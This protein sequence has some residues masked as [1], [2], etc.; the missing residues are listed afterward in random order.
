MITSIRNRYQQANRK[1]YTHSIRMMSNFVKKDFS[2]S[3]SMCTE[4]KKRMSALPIN[5]DNFISS[6]FSS[7]EPDETQTFIKTLHHKHQSGTIIRMEKD[8]NGAV[9]HKAGKNMETLADLSTACVDNDIY[10]SV[11]EFYGYRRLHSRC[12][13]I[14]GFFIDLDGHNFDDCHRAEAIRL[15]QDRLL[16]AYEHKELLIPTMITSTGRGLGLFY[17]FDRT[18]PGQCESLAGL[19]DYEKWLYDLLAKEYAKILDGPQYLEVDTSTK[20]FSR[21]CRLPGTRNSHTGTTCRLY[22]IRRRNGQPYYYTLDEINKGCHLFEN[23]GIKKEKK[24]KKENKTEKKRKKKNSV[25]VISLSEYKNNGLQ[26]HRIEWLTKVSEIKKKQGYQTGYRNELLFQLYNAAVVIMPFLEAE[27]LIRDINDTFDVPVGEKEL[28]SVMT[29]VKVHGH[30]HQKTAT[31]IEKLRIGKETEKLGCRCSKE[32]LARMENKRIKKDRNQ[33]IVE[34]RTQ[35]PDYTR[36]ELLKV[37][38]QR[39]YKCSLR[40]M[41]RVLKKAGMS[42]YK[43]TARSESAPSTCKNEIA[44][45][46]SIPC[47]V[48]TAET[49]ALS[50]LA[51]LK[52][53]NSL[54][55]TYEGSMVD[56]FIRITS[57]IKEESLKNQVMQ[58]VAY[59]GCQYKNREEIGVRDYYIND[60]NFIFQSMNQGNVKL[61]VF[62]SRVPKKKYQNADITYPDTYTYEYKEKTVNRKVCSIKTMKDKKTYHRPV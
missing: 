31:I 10:I 33:A 54:D 40:T 20:D 21:V 11:N 17:V 9:S 46:V 39:G 1:G 5:H 19:V 58:A 15:T 30:Y 50:F 29:S 26:T 36:T 45:T 28:Q 44:K 25:S 12:S 6:L 35:H 32:L 55:G 41:D 51:F 23:N 53:Y 8:A 37:V 38:C 42:F 57:S 62:G 61:Q 56:A 3:Y 2:K 13:E 43:R 59:M 47:F 16:M 48:A 27:K 34:L 22:A 7:Y 14:C 60:L 4:R 24:R 49:Y 18:I 52:E